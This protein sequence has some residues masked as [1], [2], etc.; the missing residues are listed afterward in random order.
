LQTTLNEK[1]QAKIY[2]RIIELITQVQPGVFSSMKA[3]KIVELFKLGEG[4]PPVLEVRT[5]DIA[6]GFYSFLGFTRLMS[7]NAIRKGIAEGAANGAF[8]YTAGSVP[9]LGPDGKY[10]VIINKIRFGPPQASDDEIDLETG[11][12]MMPQAIPEPAPQ[13]GEPLPV[14]GGSGGGPGTGPIPPE[15]TPQELPLGSK[16]KIVELTFTADRN[17]LFTAWNAVANLA[18]LA[19]S[20]TVT[21]KAE[22]EKGFDQSKLRNG[23]LEPLEEA[24]LIEDKK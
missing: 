11:F 24:D 13:P 23:V 3:S 12:L 22:S 17:Q 10:Q 15:P 8:G 6:D 4:K 16:E 9:S 7:A 5:S 1:K 19:G 14:P 18:D 21:V 20:V 2:E